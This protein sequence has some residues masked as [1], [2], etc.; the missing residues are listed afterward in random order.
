MRSGPTP[1]RQASPTLQTRS[2][3]GIRAATTPGSSSGVD[4]YAPQGGEGGRHGL[5]ADAQD[6]M[7]L[8][9][10]VEVEG[11]EVVTG[12]I[13]KPADVTGSDRSGHSGGELLARHPAT[14]FPR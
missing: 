12:R 3:G 14:A 9:E 4:R 13:G 7:A 1:M 6:V 11:I 8:D 10:Q 2:G 5:P